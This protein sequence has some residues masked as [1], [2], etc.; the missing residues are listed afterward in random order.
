[1]PTSS[2]FQK[3]AQSDVQASTMGSSATQSVGTRQQ[4]F[5]ARTGPSTVVG[6]DFTATAVVVRP[7][8]ATLY[9]GQTLQLSAT[10]TTADGSAVADAI[11]AWESS[12][13][14]VATVSETGLVT[15]VGAGTCDITPSAGEIDAAVP[16]AITIVA[17]LGELILADETLTFADD[18]SDTTAVTAKDQFG[19]S[20]TL[21]S[22]V[23]VASSDEGVATVAILTGTITVTGVAAGETTVTAS[24]GSI[25]SNA[26]VV[27]VTAS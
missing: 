25:T 19:D 12:D 8:A 21:P 4:G 26:C 10:A 16:C 22:G 3:R 20:M 13:T 17:A 7:L 24:K 27:T 6:G 9:I 23:T 14:D 1:M 18:S 5:P 2:N 11:D 15:V